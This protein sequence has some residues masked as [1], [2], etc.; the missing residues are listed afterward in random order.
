[1]FLIAKVKGYNGNVIIKTK[2]GSIK[3]SDEKSPL[4]LCSKQGWI[5]NTYEIIVCLPNKIVIKLQTDNEK[6][7]TI[8]K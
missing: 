5:S 2:K 7:D 3:V 4:H 6:I 8:V 1:M